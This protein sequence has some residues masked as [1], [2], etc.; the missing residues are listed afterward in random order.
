MKRILAVMSLLL[1]VPAA[2]IDIPVAELG[3]WTTLSYRNIPSNTVTTGDSGML[4]AVRRS[5]SP[6]VFKLDAPVALTGISVKARWSGGLRLPE[7]VAQG[8]SGADD[9]VLKV[10][11]VE[12]GD[13]TLNWFQRRIA[14]DWVI[15]LFE[16]ASEGSGIE[17]IHFLTTT[18]Q[19]EL[20][21]TSRRHPLSDLLY[22]T[23]IHHLDAPGEFELS[24]RFAEPVKTLGLWL[25]ADGD[26]TGS[27]FDL[28]IDSIRLHTD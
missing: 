7:G 18:L 17:R 14:A 25:S 21:G 3:D 4:I 28:H 12:A 22:E 2:A 23:H 5:A 13:K 27:S 19:Q 26:D 8:E 6:L 16:L 10:G 1:T 24:Q 15:R 20:L 9:F 11:V